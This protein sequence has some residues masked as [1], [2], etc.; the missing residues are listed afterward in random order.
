LNRWLRENGIDRPRPTHE[1]RKEFGSLINERYGV[2]E[3]SR[4]LRHSTVKVTESHYL[5]SKFKPI[6]G[7]ALDSLG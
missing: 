4:A 2:Y 6:A 3:A 5:H 1:L 7:V